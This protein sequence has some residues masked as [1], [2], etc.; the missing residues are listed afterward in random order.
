MENNSIFNYEVVRDFCGGLRND[1]ND[2]DDMSLRCCRI[3][4]SHLP[5]AIHRLVYD[6]HYGFMNSNAHESVKLVQDIVTT[7]L[8][9]VIPLDSS[10]WNDKAVIFKVYDKAFDNPFGEILF[11]IAR[12]IEYSDYWR[13]KRYIDTIDDP[14][15]KK[16]LDKSINGIKPSK[17]N[18]NKEIFSMTK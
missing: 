1:I 15:I 14:E 7:M 2:F 8:E 13:A 12:S 16:I 17:H 9:D 11:K 18:F 4:L 10:K 6:Y 5:E 3:Y